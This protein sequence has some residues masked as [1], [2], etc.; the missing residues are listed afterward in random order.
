MTRWF[1]RRSFLKAAAPLALS[2]TTISR[3]QSPVE[4]GRFND[5]D[6]PLVYDRLLKLVNEERAQAGL[7]QLER[8]DLA[9]RIASD[10]ARDMLRGRFVSHWGSDGRKPYH[11]YSFAGGIDAVQENISA[12]ENIQSLT[13]NAVIGDFVDMHVSM[14]QEVPPNDGHRRTI[15]DPRHTHVGFGLAYEGHTLRLD[16]LYLA[17]YLRID[18]FPRKVTLNKRVVLTGRL[19]NSKHFLHEVD[20]FYEPLPT[21]PDSAWLQI[22]RSVRLPDDFVRLR[23]KAPDGAAYADG[24]KGDYEW[25]RDGKFKVPAKFFKGAPGI[26]TIVFFIRTEPSDKAF[27]GAEVCI[28]SE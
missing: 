8:D 12:A 3:A 5:D 26:Y 19:L 13:P 22:P 15:L 7:N 6:L 1:N 23:P 10:H 17:R 4:R 24:G 21:P 28:L 11:R 18:D 14:I 25:S 9:S 20:V 16:Q 2:I 27:P